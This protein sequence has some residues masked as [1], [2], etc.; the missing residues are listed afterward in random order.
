[1][2]SDVETHRIRFAV[3]RKPIALTATVPAIAELSQG[4]LIGSKRFGLRPA[5]SNVR[6]A[7]WQT[8]LD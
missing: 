5:F 1:M 2:E 4:R 8:R 3:A 6:T 7:Q